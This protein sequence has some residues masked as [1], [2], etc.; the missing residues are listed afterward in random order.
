MKGRLDSSVQAIIS[1]YLD[2]VRQTKPGLLE[3]FYIYGSIA[4]GDY[5]LELSDIDFVAVTR[6]RLSKPDLAVLERIHR[7]VERSRKKPNMNGIYVTWDDLGKLPDEIPPYP[8]YKD[9]QMHEAG[10]FELN[11]VTWYELKSCGITVVGP[12]A[13]ELDYDV[14]WNG[15]I[16]R[17]HDNLNTYWRSWMRKARGLSA[18]SI[19]LYF[20]RNDIEWGVLG[21]TRLYYT[22]REN[23]ITT[24][25]G[26]GR[27][28]LGVVPE[29]WH[30]I[31]R[32]AIHARLGIAS[33][34]RSRTKRKSDTIAYMQ[35]IMEE[36]NRMFA[37]E[38]R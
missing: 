38:A 28:V 14:D 2:E 37:Q 11:L 13:A 18:Y 16:T 5:S 1:R 24:K 20:R 17:M 7:N 15:L 9:G 3:G 12:E 27:Y 25:V 35:Y 21:I 22:F 30:A 36:C 29:Q 6:E 4:L 26:A 32:E 8:Y 23:K 34:Y 31:I 33:E 10:Y 19:G